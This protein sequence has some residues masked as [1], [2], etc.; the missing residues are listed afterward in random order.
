MKGYGINMSV[1]Y[2][3]VML[4]SPLFKLEIIP[5]SCFFLKAYLYG[6][7]NN[8]LVTPAVNH[9]WF[10]CNINVQENRSRVMREGSSLYFL[11]VNTLV[12]DIVIFFLHFFYLNTVSNSSKANKKTERANWNTK[13]YKK[14]IYRHTNI[15]KVPLWSI[16]IPLS[17]WFSYLV[18][19][20]TFFKI[21]KYFHLKFQGWKKDIYTL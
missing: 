8:P 11:D 7:L 1:T 12:F 4:C 16:K 5:V 19:L 3:P 6:L 9:K 17:N 15:M 10:P 13:W 2:S 14:N 18:A 20:V 21:W